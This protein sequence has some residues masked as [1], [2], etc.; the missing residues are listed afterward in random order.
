MSNIIIA[1]D[2]NDHITA[3]TDILE[4]NGHHIETAYDGEDAIKLIHD[5]VR[6]SIPIDLVITDMNMPKADGREVAQAALDAGAKRVIINSSLHMVIPPLDGVTIISKMDILN[7]I[8]E[9]IE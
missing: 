5:F 4:L 6:R 2:N 8:G 7:E 9:L 1:D 3:L